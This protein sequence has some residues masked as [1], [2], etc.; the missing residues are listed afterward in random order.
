MGDEAYFDFEKNK[1]TGSIPTELGNL[2][3]IHAFM[4]AGNLLTGT[5]PSE[6]G[7]LSDLGKL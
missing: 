5:L 2:E 1:L 3:N 4:V 7:E 6:L